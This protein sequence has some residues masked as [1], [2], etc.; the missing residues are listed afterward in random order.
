MAGSA[1]RRD[2]APIP[3][4]SRE[5]GTQ[6]TQPPP[7]DASGQEGID[8]ARESKG[9]Q[10]DSSSSRREVES[11]RRWLARSDAGLPPL[12]ENLLEVGID[13]WFLYISLPTTG[14]PEVREDSLRRVLELPIPD[15]LRRVVLRDIASDLS[16]QSRQSEFVRRYGFYSNWFNRLTYTASRAAQ[17]NLQ[18]VG[19][20]VVDAVFGLFPRTQ[21]TPAERRAYRISREL[22]KQGRSGEIDSK[23][24]ARLEEQV[25]EALAAVDLERGRWALEH[26]NPDLATFYARGAL[27]RRPD[28]G[29][30]E[31]LRRAA[32][33]ELARRSR[34][35]VISAQVG[36]PDRQPPVRIASPALLRA[37]L[38]HQPSDLARLFQEDRADPPSPDNADSRTQIFLNPGDESLAWVLSTLADREQSP[39]LT[40][41]SWAERLT[42]NSGLTPQQSAWL[43]ALLQNPRFNPDLRLAQSEATRRGHLTRFVFLGPEAARSRAYRF[44]S[45]FAAAWNALA[46][47]G[48]FY[49]FEVILRTGVVAFRP[50]P[51]AEEMLDSAAVLL[52]SAP[53]HP[54]SRWVATWLAEQYAETGRFESARDLLDRFG[55]LDV[56]KARDLDR[57]E[58]RGFL[59]AALALD[60]S[61]P[62]RGA[63]LQKVIEISPGSRLARRAAQALEQ[64]EVRGEP[65]AK[66][67]VEVLWTTLGQWFSRPLPAG[68]PGQPEWFDGD[69]GNGEI[70]T[71]DFTLEAEGASPEWVVVSYRVRAGGK[72]QVLR[73]AIQLSDQ[74][75]GLRQWI[76]LLLEEQRRSREGAPGLGRPR[77]PYEVQGGVGVGGI[78]FYPRLLPI[79]MDRQDLM[80]YTD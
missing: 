74:P 55:Q 20:L 45:R 44:S 63:M 17:G 37:A 71:I 28:N 33:I 27:G 68:L 36:Y 25:H 77:I 11:I 32:S 61:N 22:E 75:P 47:I 57:A 26:G 24:L 72:R 3:K 30:A 39:V 67:K 80:L 42:E 59:S 8:L 31:D 12:H 52:R 41:R 35:A 40:L 65:G 50:P 21:A 62:V 38:S 49:G 15:N 46:G 16:F 78:D 13:P 58:A 23:R 56:E 5:F 76:S 69:P 14:M 2:P 9:D 64:P 51:P 1:S 10:I 48:I 34:A 60:V 6:T 19:Q 29:D 18:A 54:E 73:E 66:L 7:G 79:E 70:E 4:D 43:S 53:L